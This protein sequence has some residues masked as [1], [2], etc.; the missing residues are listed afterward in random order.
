MSD[1]LPSDSAER[2]RIP[3]C[4]GVLDY[5]PGALAEVA[6]ISWAGNQKH[7]PGQPLHHARGKSTDHADCIARH[8]IQ[9]G[10]FDV[11]EYTDENG[12]KQTVRIRHSAALAWRALML[13]QEELEAEGA[14][15]ARG[16]RK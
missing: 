5:A 8:L 7:N 2:K 14:P 10:T 3:I 16:A 4:T 9:R 12:E 15:M 13:L 1:T 6:K 11:I